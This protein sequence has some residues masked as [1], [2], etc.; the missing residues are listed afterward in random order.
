MTYD[1]VK[2][3]IV[4][5]VNRYTP[6]DGDYRLPYSVRMKSVA[7]FA[8]LEANLMSQKYIG[9]EHLLLGILK[10]GDGVAAKVLNKYGLTY[11]YAKSM[12]GNILSKNP[13]PEEI[14]S[15]K[16]SDPKLL[17]E[18]GKMLDKFGKDLTQLAKKIIWIRL[19]EETRKLNG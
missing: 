14:Q 11:E 18:R 12:I 19:S 10:E 5:V 2:E 16:N 6:I 13:M 4:E 17:K 15:E 8:V 3:E 1:N 7:E 9:P